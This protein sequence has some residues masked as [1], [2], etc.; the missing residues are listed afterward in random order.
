MKKRVADIIVETLVNN[1]IED[2]F[3]VVGGGAMHID[4]A[5]ALND[6]IKKYFNHHEQACTMAAEGYAK[7]SGRMAAVSIT[8]GPGAI[9]TLN[10]VQGAYVDNVPM[11]IIAGH[12]RW[13][14]TV[15]VTGLNLRCRGVQ[16]F[17]IV[18]AVKGMT[19]YSVMITD[20]LMIKRE[21]NKA[22]RIANDG[23]RGPVWLSVPLDIQG[24]QVEESDLLPDEDFQSYK[25]AVNSEVFVKINEYIREARRPVI[26]AGSGVRSSGS[27]SEFRN[28]VNKLHIPTLSGALL[29]DIMSEG[30]KYYYG[31][32]GA[33]GERKGNF[34]LQNADLIIAIGNSLA[35]KQTG[36]NQSKFAPAA[37]IIMVDVEKDEMLKPGIR[38]DYPVCADAKDFLAMALDFIDTW[39]EKSD[40]VSYC[41]SV[42]EKLGGID[43]T[44]FY[45]SDERVPQKV[46]WD[47]LRSKLPS[48]GLLA[49]GNSSGIVGG[50]QK[51][52]LS[53]DQRVIVNYNSG[54]MGDDL[55]EA[56]GI[57]VAMRRSVVCVTGDGSIMM[58][59]QELQT[60]KYY[61]LPIKVI[62]LSNG[63][64][65]ALR[66][67]YANFF[68]GVYIGCDEKSGISMPDFEKI[69][70]AFDFKYKRCGNVGN[71]N[72]SVDW[73]LKEDGY[74]FLEI[75]QRYDDPI[76][77]KVMSKMDETG[78]FITPGLE[79]MY[80]FLKE[81]IIGELM[82][83]Q[84]K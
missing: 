4:N 75:S 24:M 9:N 33:S 14:T 29:P 23:R 11:I 61:N 68:D 28:L 45:D 17:D 80:P 13:D 10:G 62:V 70:R 76:L 82:I 72:D 43:D 21:I 63:G 34:I 7:A 56:I 54:S 18:P 73:L 67:T 52:V 69:A 32:S 35:T 59:L 37:K 6:N 46:L 64:Y 30:T 15:N 74:A 66:Q 81:D 58:N 41:N 42:A 12:P 71:V 57:A 5:L 20:S 60:I 27:V 40:W 79:D 77:P 48:N 8:S 19:K 3:V 44:P 1:N 16:E 36:F 47:V 84:R 49:L 31:T 2:C 65:G 83:Y 51:S 39:N 25:S 22:I 26:L 53:P 55:P 78:V 50:L 38:I